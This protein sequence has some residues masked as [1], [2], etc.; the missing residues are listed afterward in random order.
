MKK[1]WVI[2]II[3][4]IL[5][6]GLSIFHKQKSEIISNPNEFIEKI[7]SLES[8]ITYL[9][10]IRDSISCRID[11]VYKKLDNNTK[12]Y[13]KNFITIINN[14][15]NEDVKFFFEYINSNKHRLDSLCN[16]TRY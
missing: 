12:E 4:I 3:L 14:D 8:E 7:D 6:I 11:T 5:L 1:Y 13:E 10:T 16:S 15:T 2:L 9:T